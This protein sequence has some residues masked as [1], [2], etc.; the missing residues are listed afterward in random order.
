MFDND[1]KSLNTKRMMS[2]LIL[3]KMNVHDCLSNP[4]DDL[5]V[6]S[7]SAIRLCDLILDK[8]NANNYYKN[9]NS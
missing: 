2:L 6:F 9:R 1:K 5:R 4:R 7:K 3:C 8:T